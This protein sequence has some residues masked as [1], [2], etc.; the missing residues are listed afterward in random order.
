MKEEAENRYFERA[1]SEELGGEH[2][3]DLSE[4]I[5]ASASRAP[6]SMPARGRTGKLGRRSP[7]PPLTRRNSPLGAIMA[8]LLL[9]VAAV[10]V[11]MGMNTTRPSEIKETAGK[12][13]VNTPKVQPRVEPAPMPQPPASNTPAIEPAP[14]Q[15]KP[16]EKQDPPAKPDEVK[17]PEEKPPEK[18]PETPRQPE[19]TEVKRPPVEPKPEERPVEPRQ[20]AVVAVV[21]ELSRKGALKLRYADAETWRAAESAEVL[22]EGVQLSASGHADI[23]LS[24]GALLRFNG[25]LVL[26]ANVEIRSEDLYVDNLDCAELKLQSGDLSAAMNGIAVF[27]AS[28]G[29]LSISCVQGNVSTSDGAVSAGKTANL[30]ARGLSKAQPTNTET[31][32]RKH[33]MLRNLPERVLVREDFEAASKDRLDRGELSEGIASANAKEAGVSIYFS[34]TFKLRAGDFVRFRYRVSRAI[35]EL[36]LQF[37]VEGQGNYRVMLTPVKVGEWLEVEVALTDLVRTLDK[38]SRIEIGGTM[39]FFQLWAIAP[40]AVKLEVDWF[41]ISRKAAD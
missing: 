40:Q 14:E 26:G 30:T 24:S 6:S 33:P 3:P 27:S 25:E 12:S 41:E 34:D 18:Q 2:A 4:R 32:A 1:L 8:V 17:K 16:E 21:K 39:K 7:A 5:L 23:R 37:G 9:I 10:V 31:L 28:R 19:G 29:T 35:E 11:V 15:P 38:S 20:P 22:R 13:S 36:V